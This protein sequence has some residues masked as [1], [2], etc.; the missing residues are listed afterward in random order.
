MDI[1]WSASSPAS[2]TFVSTEREGFADLVER[3]SELRVQG[4]GYL[5]VRRG[6]TFPV[7][8]LGFKGFAAVVH[9]MSDDGL[10]SLLVADQHRGRECGSAG[11][12]RP[13]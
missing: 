1:S 8:A 12:G 11:D 13:G 6:A 3:F 2:G 5:E 10:V 9:L 4:Q 7:C